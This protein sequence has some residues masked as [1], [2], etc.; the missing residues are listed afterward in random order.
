[1]FCKMWWWLCASLAV[2]LLPCS[3]SGQYPHLS[4]GLKPSS[5]S[6][7][8]Q[9]I[10]G[11]PKAT[12]GLVACKTNSLVTQSQS[13]EM[14]ID[15]YS[16]VTLTLDLP[17]LLSWLARGKG[18]ERNGG[19]PWLPPELARRSKGRRDGS[20]PTHG[21]FFL[22]PRMGNIPAPSDATYCLSV[23]KLLTSNLENYTALE[24]YESFLFAE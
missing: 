10:P 16:Y 12:H 14:L 18:D 8:G 20:S 11:V 22:Y 13:L 3:T 4:R 1:M 21:L 5:F 2:L 17:L 24:T 9:K 6:G 19:L 23:Y 7:H 15:P